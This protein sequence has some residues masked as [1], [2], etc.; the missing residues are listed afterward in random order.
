MSLFT[1]V[2]ATIIADTHTSTYND[3]CPICQ[4]P[5]SEKCGECS[6]SASARVNS[7]TIDEGARE[8]NEFCTKCEIAIGMCNHAYHSHCITIWLKNN[9]TCCVDNKPWKQIKSTST[10]KQIPISNQFSF[11]RSPPRPDPA[12]QQISNRPSF[13]ER[14]QRIVNQPTFVRSPPRPDPVIQLTDDQIRYQIEH[15]DSIPIEYDDD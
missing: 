15:E 7:N 12:I 9:N 10:T 11:E 4:I 6:A 3:V 2:N 5:L 1:I 14:P 8:C 13:R